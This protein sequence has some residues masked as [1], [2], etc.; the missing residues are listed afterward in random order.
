MRI[1]TL[2]DFIE[3]NIPR[4]E[5]F[6][7]ALEQ[8]ELDCVTPFL[9]DEVLGA[10]AYGS[11]NTG[12]CNVASDIDYL[13]ITTDDSHNEIVREA[14]RRALEERHVS[15]QTRVINEKNAMAGIHTINESFKEH[16]ALSVDQYGHRGDVNPLDVLDNNKVPFRRAARET[17][18]FYLGHL[19][20]FGTNAHTSEEEYVRML[21]YV[22]E[23]P[24]HAMGVAIQH[25]RGPISPG[26]ETECVDT[27]PE[28]MREYERLEYDPSLMEDLRVIGATRRDYINLLERRQMGDVSEGSMVSE[29][30]DMLDRVSGCYQNARH[31]IQENARLMVKKS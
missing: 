14:T 7:A 1:F 30:S 15:I 4:P 23:L 20:N 6:S 11:V 9:G 19:T 8:F 24:Y 13:M 29:Y 18:N 28:L 12:D 2:Q 26:G 3:G 22:M 21:K 27:K 10:I 5:D 16:L 31:F 17:I 25:D